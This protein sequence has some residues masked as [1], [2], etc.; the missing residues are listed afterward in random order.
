M[1]I[2]NQK[3]NGYNKLFKE[4]LGYI[5]SQCIYTVAKLSV[6]DIIGDGSKSISELSRICQADED[7]LYRIMRLLGNQDIFTEH[8]QK[9]FSNNETSHYLRSDVE[10]T[11]RDFSILINAVPC[12]FPAISRLHDCVKS[13]KIP[14]DEYYGEPVFNHVAK[15]AELASL[16]D[17][18]M[19]SAHTMASNSL[20]ESY[21][22]DRYATFADIGG[23]SGEATTKVL[24]RYP[25]INAVVFDLP[26]VIERTGMRLRDDGLSDRCT[27][28]GGDFF[29]SIPVEADLYFMRQIL[30]DWTHDQSVTILKNLRASAKPGSR[31]LVS[32]CVVNEQPKNENTPFYDLL[33]LYI[34]GGRERTVSE[35]EAIFDQSGFRLTNIVDTGFWFGAIEAKAV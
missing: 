32:D 15:N 29:R 17:A 6:A 10:H 14:F 26:H 21:S 25:H 24:K 16:L 20:L 9:V 8:G 31:L 33:M 5:V 2:S 23:G 30:H 34:T 22:L 1:S 19:L 27:L 4:T 35:F 13:G 18:A 12:P 28:V 11:F 7:Y 3:E